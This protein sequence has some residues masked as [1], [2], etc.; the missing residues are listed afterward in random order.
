LLLVLLT[1]LLATLTAALLS[2]LT[3][4]LL[5]L[6]WVLV[7]ALLTTLL[8]ALLLLVLVLLVLVLVRHEK[9]LWVR[10][11]YPVQVGIRTRDRHSLYS[12][13]P[14]NKALTPHESARTGIA[15]ICVLIGRLIT[16]SATSSMN[17]Q[18][19]SPR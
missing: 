19:D 17:R 14:A 16:R 6:A 10:V 15:R 1:A 8:A 2:A 9:F 18:S 5:L 12:E 13:F 4:L 7:A 11:H 3:G